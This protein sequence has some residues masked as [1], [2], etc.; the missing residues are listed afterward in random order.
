V[1]FFPA[2]P[3]AVTA[4]LAAVLRHRGRSLPPRI[5]SAPVSLT[6][7]DGQNQPRERGHD[8]GPA[9]D[10]PHAE[11]P[12]TA[13][14]DSQLGDKIAVQIGGYACGGTAAWLA[15]GWRQ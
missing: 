9:R 4:I 5:R 11:P 7:Q 2:L 8:R 10:L 6:S 1:L 3:L 15:A 12:V 14:P 13:Q